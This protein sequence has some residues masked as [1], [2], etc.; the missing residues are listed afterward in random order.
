MLHIVQN[1]KKFTKCQ[2]AAVQVRGVLPDDFLVGDCMC[3]LIPFATLPSTV[4]R[5][6]PSTSGYSGPVPAVLA[7]RHKRKKNKD[8]GCL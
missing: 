8:A 7:F 3:S 5:T 6:G 4:L 2:G 1:V